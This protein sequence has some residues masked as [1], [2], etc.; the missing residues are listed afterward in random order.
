MDC[1]VA[2]TSCSIRTVYR[3]RDLR[4]SRLCVYPQRRLLRNRTEGLRTRQTPPPDAP[5]ELAPQRSECGFRRRKK[6][7]LTHGAFSPLEGEAKCGHQPMALGS[8][9]AMSG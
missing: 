3:A 9:V 2:S 1:S 5:N 6:A 8:Q 7:A 4:A